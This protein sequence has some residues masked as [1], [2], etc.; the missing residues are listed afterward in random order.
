MARLPRGLRNN[1]PGNINFANQPLA[2]LETGVSSPRF[3][4]FPTMDDGINALL[5]QLNRYFV[6]G[7]NTVATIIY[8][9]APPIENNTQAYVKFVADK[10]SVKPTDTLSFTPQVASELA[11][12]ISRLENGNLNFTQDHVLDLA[13]KLI[14]KPIR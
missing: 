7:I 4:K 8:K 13:K 9:W 10:L 12:A 14:I 2:T 1:N 5:N 11:Y 3:A 6:R